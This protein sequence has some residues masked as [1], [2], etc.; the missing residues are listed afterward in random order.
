M[1]AALSLWEG[2]GVPNETWRMDVVFD[3]APRDDHR[4]QRPPPARSPHPLAALPRGLTLGP[5]AAADKAGLAAGTPAV[6]TGREAEV[7]DQ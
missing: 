2:R 7:S 1:A 3:K 4:H 6:E 5:Q